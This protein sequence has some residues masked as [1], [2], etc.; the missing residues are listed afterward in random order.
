LKLSLCLKTSKQRSP[1]GNFAGVKAALAPATDG[2]SFLTPMNISPGRGVGANAA[3]GG[4][5]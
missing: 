1:S 5:Y 4:I 3:L 2:A